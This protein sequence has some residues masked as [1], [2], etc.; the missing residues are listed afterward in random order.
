MGLI[1]WFCFTTLLPHR[2]HTAAGDDLN[3]VSVF[4]VKLV[5]FSQA[6]GENGINEEKRLGGG[7]RNT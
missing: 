7:V 1:S 4:Q 6:K 2:S 3:V 5:K